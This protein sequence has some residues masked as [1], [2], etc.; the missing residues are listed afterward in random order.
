MPIEVKSNEGAI[1][2]DLVFQ[3][4]AAFAVAVNGVR[5]QEVANARES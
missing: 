1:R 4:V 3:G 2:R 5:R